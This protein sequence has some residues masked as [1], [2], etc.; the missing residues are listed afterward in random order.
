MKHILLVD[1]DSS[2]LQLI[3][4]AL[5]DYDVTTA[6]DGF[7][8][9]AA[10]ERSGRFDLLITDYLMPEMFGDELIARARA[11]Q[12]DL[13][14]LVVTGHGWI[15]DREAAPWWQGHAHLDKPFEVAALREQVAALIGGADH[16][17]R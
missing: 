5:S 4:R 8:A 12:P 14:V 9:L 2:T 13:Q 15:L 3:G 17:G 11:R 7:E 1:D 10:A 16:A 6:H